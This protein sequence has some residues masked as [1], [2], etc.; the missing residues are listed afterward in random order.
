MAV[1]MNCTRAS[2][3]PELCADASFLQARGKWMI[4]MYKAGLYTSISCSMYMMVRLFLV[5]S[6]QTE[7]HTVSLTP[8]LG[9]QDLVRQELDWAQGRRYPGEA[10]MQGT[11][12]GK[13]NV[14]TMNRSAF[15]DVSYVQLSRRQPSNTL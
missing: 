15:E 7:S 2:E 6:V 4:P 14:Q 11:S 3:L 9:T 13:P 1:A 12:S 8:W 5:S 10:N